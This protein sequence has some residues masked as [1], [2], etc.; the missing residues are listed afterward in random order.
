MTIAPTLNTQVSFEPSL[1]PKAAQ[2]FNAAHSGKYRI[3][4]CGG[5]VRGGKTFGVGGTLVTLHRRF[6][7]ARS[8]VVRDTLPNLR[9]TTL[10]TI[11]KLMPQSFVKQFK[12]DPQFQWKFTNGGSFQFFAEQDATDKERKRWNGLEMNWIWL[13][14]AEELQRATYDKALERLGSYFIPKHVGKQPHPILFITV[15]PTSTWVREEFYDKFLAG[16]LPDYVCYIP[17]TIDD[18]AALEPSFRESLNML[19]LTNPIKYKIFVEGNWDVKEKTGGEWYHEFDYGRHTGTVP[20]LPE[21]T[22]DVHI[23]LDFN[24]VPYMTMGCFQVDLQPFVLQIRFFREYCLA[25]PNNRT[26][27]LCG[28]LITDYL[29]K[30]PRPVT[31]HGDRQGENRVEG[32]GNFRR[33]D[34]VRTSLAP[35][36]HNRSNQVNKAV[37]VSSVMRD[38]INDVLAGVVIWNGRRIEI[39]IDEKAC[40]TLIEDLATTLEDSTGIKKEHAKDAKGDKYEKNGHALSMFTYGVGAVLWDAFREWK[41]QRGKIGEETTSD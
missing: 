30:Y 24:T 3:I 35:Y 8:M 37:T 25:T 5:A 40:P 16:T 39:L 15:N 23:S 26:D 6:P 20:F 22:N 14:Q 19:K 12:G 32:E 9:T 29:I 2:L 13:E 27:R 18:N 33:F 38:F 11:E 21:L 4:V 36:L 1:F 28:R 7:G 17:M 31:Y 10:P 34:R 41:K